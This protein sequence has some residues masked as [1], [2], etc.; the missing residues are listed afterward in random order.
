MRS[1]RAGDGS[2]VVV[3]CHARRFVL[4]QSAAD[5]NYLIPAAVPDALAA[6]ARVIR[7]ERIDLIVPTTDADV[8]TIARHR[9]R[10][11]CRVFLPSRASVERCA[12]KYALT[13]WLRARGVPVPATV[14]VRRLGDIAAG[15]RRLRPKGRVWCRVR[16]GNGSF[17][18]LDVRRPEQA[19]AWIAYWAAMRGVRAS[20]FTLS[21]YLPGRDFACQSLWKDGRLVLVKAFERL[22]YFVGGGQPSR[23]SSVAA[24][25]R[26][27]SDPRPV[28]TAVAAVRALDPRATGLFSVDLKE[29]AA[30]HP[31]VTEINAGR[32]LAGT[33]LLDLTGQHNMAATYV[34]LALGEPAG[35]GAVHDAT[36]DHY[37]VRDLDTLPGILHVDQVFDGIIDGQPASRAVHS[38]FPRRRTPR[39]LRPH[40][41]QQEAQGRDR[42]SRSA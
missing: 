17:G 31:C 7:A 36:D 40:T 35:V 28:A 24:L 41:T 9:R 14:A 27:V 42:G 8:L 22:E 2:L 26:T 12:D 33:N 20:S 34:R 3:G 23:V 39:A 10:L 1:L 30:G 6:L 25:A 19:R 11:P 13:R 18:A 29:N 16:R 15:F 4:T 21:E 5:R 37:I 32:F 38:S